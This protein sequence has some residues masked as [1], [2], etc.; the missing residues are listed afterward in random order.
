MTDRTDD[1][2]RADV[3]GLGGTDLVS[4]Q[5]ITVY[6]YNMDISE[7]PLLSLMKPGATTLCE[8]R[9]ITIFLFN[10]TWVSFYRVFL[11]VLVSIIDI[12]G[13]GSGDTLMIVRSTHCLTLLATII[14][15]R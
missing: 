8:V 12:S 5:R 13:L 10:G 14:F 4:V 3:V 1:G 9:L 2:K 11:D 6:I 15:L 7:K